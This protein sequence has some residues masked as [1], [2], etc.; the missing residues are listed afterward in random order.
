MRT[1]T[2]ENALS[3]GT[4]VGRQ[5]IV[6]RDQQVAAYELLFRASAEAT[7]AEFDE[8]GHAALRVMVN[9]F[10]SLGAE[11]VLGSARGFFNVNRELLLS[12]SVEAL[13]K[14][15][16][17]LEV[18]ED[19][20]PT[21]DVA[22][23][24]RALQEDGYTLALDDWVEDDPRESLLPFVEFVKVDLP[25][26]PEGGLRRL[27]RTLRRADV[28][29]L[30]EKVETQEE[31]DRCHKLGF[32]LFQGYYFA[33]PTVLEGAPVDVTT[34]TLLKII[35][36]IAQQAESDAIVDT[37]KQDA[38]LGIDLL[39]LVNTAGR[40]TRMRLSTLDSAVRHLGL[41]QLGRWVTIL[42]YVQGAGSDPRNPLLNAAAHRGR[43]MELLVGTRGAE[44][45]ASD[46]RERAFLVGMLSLAEALLRRPL[47]GLLADLQL[48]PAV[49]AALLS[50]EGELGRL[51]SLVV[52][53]ERGELAKFEGE[54][55]SRDL[56]FAALQQI[57]NDA[58]A[59]VHGL[60]ESL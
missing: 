35:Q 21:P 40:A 56:D 50:G 1:G 25:A 5:P 37:L 45:G 38:Q 41:K 36:Q 2:G 51:L 47:V 58:Y 42:L 17:V 8:V 55:A 52:G 54:L 12:E 15:R 43:L 53:L 44:G 46:Q 29:L 32:D 20:E 49:E 7:V 28:Q 26:I 48:E 59:W 34:S 33:R 31:F 14:D 27:V 6:D 22:A 4:F 23:R 19:V 9:T 39:R 18:L 57:D 3:E 24:C 30:A 16:V 60:A 11:A 10:A 13:P